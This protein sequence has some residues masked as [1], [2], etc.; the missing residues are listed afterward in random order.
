MDLGRSYRALGDIMELK[1]NTPGT[2]REYRPSLQIFTQLATNNP[3]NPAVQDELA[4]AYE[5]L[6][7]GL[8]RA[9]NANAEII[10]N[11]QKSRAIREELVRRDNSNLK[12]RRGLALILMKLGGASDPHQ[13]EAIAAI[14]RGVATLESLAADD[15]NYGRARREVG[16]GYY[17]LGGVLMAGGDYADALDSRQKALAIREKFSAADPQNA[18]ASFDLAGAHVDLAEALTAKGDPVRAVEEARKGITILTTLLTA[19]PTNVI[20]HATLPSTRKSSATLSRAPARIQ[21]CRPQT[22]FAPG[23]ARA[24]PIRKQERFFPIFAITAPC[25]QQTRTSRKNLPS[26]RGIVSRQSNS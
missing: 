8:G 23:P 19:D 9:A 26:A 2:I 15:P 4:P 16:W 24:R 10:T 25:R 7:D 6:A 20:Y 12:L 14:R 1:G 22:D 13:A 17:Q 3:A 18:Q 5:T 21:A 11:C